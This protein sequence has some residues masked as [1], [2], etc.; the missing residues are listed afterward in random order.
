VARARRL[1]AAG[2]YRGQDGCRTLAARFD[3]ISTSSSTS[4]SDSSTPERMFVVP[5]RSTAQGRLS[6]AS[7]IERFETCVFA[8]EDD[9]IR[10]VGE[11]ATKEAALEAV[12]AAGVAS[13]SERGWMQVGDDS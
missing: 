5:L 11:F 4:R 1:S 2:I 7:F 10:T 13:S 8:V 12:G 3:E 9:S 6:G